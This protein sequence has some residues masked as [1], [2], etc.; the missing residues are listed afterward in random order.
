MEPP[1]IHIIDCNSSFVKWGKPAHSVRLRPR[2]D[3]RQ[4]VWPGMCLRRR[5]SE[6]PQSLKIKFPS[7]SL[8]ET[9]RY[10]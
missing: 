10:E 2:T 8:S 3:A 5:V 4:Y 1:R 7:V 6:Q 9:G